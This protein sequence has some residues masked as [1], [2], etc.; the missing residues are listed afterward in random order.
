MAASSLLSNSPNIADIVGDATWP[1]MVAAS[2]AIEAGKLTAFSRLMAQH[3]FELDTSRLFFDPFYAYRRLA[4]AH[5]SNDEALKA[6]AIEMF[7]KYKALERRRRDV[8]AFDTLS[9]TRH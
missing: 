3:G 4:L 8:S 7:E 9:I 5:T 1:G 2:L 6:L